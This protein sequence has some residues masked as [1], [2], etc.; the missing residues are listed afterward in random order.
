MRNEINRWEEKK[1]TPLVT[2][3][4][5]KEKIGGE[6]R[7]ENEDARTSYMYSLREKRKAKWEE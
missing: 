4:K 5:I 7:K 1:K 6:K 3:H 2:I